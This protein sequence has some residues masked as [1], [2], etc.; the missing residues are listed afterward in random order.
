MRTVVLKTYTSDTEIYWKTLET[1]LGYEVHQIQYDHLLHSRHNEVIEQ[2]KAIN[3][4]LIVFIGAVESS[5]GR[6]ILQL[7]NLCRLREIAPTIHMCGDAGDYPWWPILDEY[8][9]AKC[10]SVQVSIDGNRDS[11]INYFDN[12][13]VKLVPVDPTKF[14]YPKLWNEKNTFIGLTGNHGHGER[15]GMMDYL[16]SRSDCQYVFGVDYPALVNFMMDCKIIVNCPMTGSAKTDHVKA[17]V[18]ETGWARACLFERTN[19][20]TASWFD[21]GIDYVEYED[22]RDLASK[23]DWASS[24][25]DKACDM[26]YSFRNRIV[27]EHHPVIFWRDVFA[28]GKVLFAGA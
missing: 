14:L 1:I 20:Y 4:E 25:L 18:T 24:N 12:G 21:P 15:G 17:R 5:H 22:V 27:A 8:D 2:T 13:I 23:L 16:K 11:P 26:A 3:P 6:P 19:R 9:K 28:K 10:F 7:D